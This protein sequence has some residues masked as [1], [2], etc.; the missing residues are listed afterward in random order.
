MRRQPQI[1]TESEVKG[2]LGGGDA[3]KLCLRIE[4]VAA[5]LAGRA[6]SGTALR[7]DDRRGNA[8]EEIGAS[9]SCL[10]SGKGL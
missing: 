1:V 6:V 3:L 2:E 10:R 7:G 4:T 9:I 5:P 8:Y